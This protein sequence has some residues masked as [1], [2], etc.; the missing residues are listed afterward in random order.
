MSAIWFIF[1]VGLLNT[2]L[3]FAIAVRLGRRYRAATEAGSEWDFDDDFT[4]PAPPVYAA[5]S[6]PA[7][8]PEPLAELAADEPEGELQGDAEAAEWSG[9]DVGSAPAGPSVSGP[10]GDL[11]D[12]ADGA[13]TAGPSVSEPGGDLLDDANGAAPPSPAPAPDVESRATVEAS[14]PVSAARPS[15][16]SGETRASEATDRSGAAAAEV[17]HNGL[18][19]PTVAADDGQTLPGERPDAA[20]D[21]AESEKAIE[22]FLAE[23]TQYQGRLDQADAELR[24]QAENPDGDSLRTCLESLLEA[25]REYAEQRE[26][27]RVQLDR[28]CGEK[29]EFAAAGEHLRGAVGRQDRQVESTARA[30][31]AFP[32]DDNLAQGCR[33]MMDETARLM[34]ANFQV[35]DALHEASGAVVRAACQPEEL[36]PAKRSDALT[37][38]ESR[39]ALER[40]LVEWLSDDAGRV[41]SL[42]VAAIDVDGFSRV[43]RQFGH[44]TGDLLLQ[45]IGKL[46]VAEQHGQTR[47]ARSGGERFVMLFPD[48]DLRTAT[49]SVERLRQI[50]ESAHFDYKRDDIRI[51]VSCGVAEATS[52]DTPES[53]LARAEATLMEAKRYGRNRTF[54]HEGKYPAPVAPPKFNIEPRQMPL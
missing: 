7:A 44:A 19:A 28:V 49:N 39:V 4:L 34:D 27:A 41:E 32:Y 29:P 30:I 53:I 12:D 33:V 45:A 5:A 46:L 25:G 47:L 48:T 15:D 10:G 36:E 9:A 14:D 43:N 22:A 51:T 54:L 52:G 21:L 42:A 35:R 6:D 50:V 24:L 18:A 1:V 40:A 2:C 26:Q 3:G 16:P 11:P 20:A 17:P 23:V 38:V 31:T 37:G 13:A 8:A